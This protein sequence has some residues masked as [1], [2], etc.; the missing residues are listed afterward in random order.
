VT[1]GEHW[2]YHDTLGSSFSLYVPKGTSGMRRVK[3]YSN[4]W[5]VQLSG[6]FGSI[7]MSK[8]SRVSLFP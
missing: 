3:V 2:V 5:H 6:A 8:L 1:T 7:G 4:E